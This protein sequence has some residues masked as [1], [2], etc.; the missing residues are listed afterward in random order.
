MVSRDDRR[1]FLG[2][3][4]CAGGCALVGPLATRLTGAEQAPKPKILDFRKLTCCCYECKPEVCQLLKASLSNEERHQLSPAQLRTLEE[5]KKKAQAN[6]RERFKREF[7]TDEVFC[8]GCKAEPAK[9]GYA[10]KAC[11]VRACVIGKGLVSCAHCREL[12]DC[13]RQLWVNYPKFREHV[14]GLQKQALG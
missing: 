9:L 2:A 1:R 7:S 11:D 5:G 14:L 8:F 13:Q 4:F 10:V 12:A 6:W 3:T